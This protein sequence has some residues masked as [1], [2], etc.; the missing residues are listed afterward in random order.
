MSASRVEHKFEQTL[1][2]SK[3][4]LSKRYVSR[5]LKTTNFNNVVI[6]ASTG[7][8]TRIEHEVKVGMY[9]IHVILPSERIGKS[10]KCLHD[11][12]KMHTEISKVNTTKEQKKIN[13]LRDNLFVNQRWVHKNHR[14]INHTCG[15]WIKINDL[16]NAILY[17]NRIS[18]LKAF[19]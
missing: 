18:R 13:L 16:V 10:F 14:P 2:F 17:C 8:I 11:Y 9:V 7:N 1:D 6:D 3:P 12:K 15:G 19:L 4:K 5:V